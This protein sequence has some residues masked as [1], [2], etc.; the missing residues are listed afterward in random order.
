MI[1]GSKKKRIFID[2]HDSL[3]ESFQRNLC[4]IKR[5]KHDGIQQPMHQF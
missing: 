1:V 3:S 2:Q 5:V 4:G